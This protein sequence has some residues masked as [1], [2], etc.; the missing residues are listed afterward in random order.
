MNNLLSAST[1]FT[2]FY[3]A[4]GFNPRSFR[5]EYLIE[6]HQV[7][8]VLKQI[9]KNI[10]L[11][12]DAILQSQKSQK[13]YYNKKHRP[14]KLTEIGSLVMLQAAGISFD[15]YAHYPNS[16]LPNHIG[17]FKVLAVD[18]SLEN[19][20]LKLPPT[21]LIHLTFHISLVKEYFEPSEI[22]DRTTLAQPAP[23]TLITGEELFEVEKNLDNCKLDSRLG[24]TR[25]I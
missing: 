11:A 5:E 6:E 19:V 17:P 2:P 13:K 20:T 24:R 4:L 7:V 8:N 22:N 15:A 3:L 1:G 21:M 12:K 9:N 14:A 10:R 16:V 25:E 23:V 18:P